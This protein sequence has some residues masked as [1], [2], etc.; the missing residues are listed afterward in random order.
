MSQARPKRDVPQPP[1][2]NDTKA[3]A[4]RLTAANEHLKKEIAERFGAEDRIRLIIDTIPVMTWSVRPDGIVDFLNQRWMDYTG[5]SLGQYV[6]D[7]VG[8]IAP[9]DTPRVLERWRAQM[10]HNEAYDDEMLL[11]GADGTYRQFLVRT[12]PLLDESGRLVEWYGVST[13]IEDRKRAEAELEESL[14]HLRALTASL[15]RAQNDERRRIAQML[16]ET[17]AQDLAAVKML[18]GRL[19]RTMASDADRP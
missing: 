17:T 15:M 12:A 3:E 6:V 14:S 1:E 9:E 7:P 11:R 4:D 2:P 19:G 18:L 8:R 10:A 16:H 13:D 5:L